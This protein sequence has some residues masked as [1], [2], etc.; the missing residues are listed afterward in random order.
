[1]TTHKIVFVERIYSEN[2]TVVC[3]IKHFDLKMITFCLV[4][5]VLN[6][7][8]LDDRISNK[9]VSKVQIYQEKTGISDEAVKNIFSLMMN[10]RHETKPS[11]GTH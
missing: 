7:F 2:H 8:Q 4:L 3:K 9:I 11:T 10:P 6:A 1:M 5:S